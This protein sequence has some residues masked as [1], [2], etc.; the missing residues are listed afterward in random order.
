MGKLGKGVGKGFMYMVGAGIFVGV[1][2]AAYGKSGG[3]IG[4]KRK[5]RGRTP[6]R[7]VRLP[8]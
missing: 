3:R 2:V 4:S 5:R 8:R 1:A 6:P 7:G